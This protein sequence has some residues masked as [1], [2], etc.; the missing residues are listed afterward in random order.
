[1]AFETDMPAFEVQG[2]QINPPFCNTLTGA[3]C[4]NPPPG[5]KFYPIFS[6][7]KVNGSC[8]WREGG[9]FL[10]G[11]INDFGGSSKTEYGSL[12]KIVYPNT[13]FKTLKTFEDFN[14]G[15]M[16]NPCPASTH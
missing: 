7:A 9:A 15:V 4:V 3:H 5:A 2:A 12:L 10:P 6:T 14:S 11:T 13:G 8:V 16:N 1:M